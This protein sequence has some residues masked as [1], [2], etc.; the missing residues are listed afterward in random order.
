[1]NLPY[2]IAAARRLSVCRARW[3]PYR[4]TRWRWHV[5]FAAIDIAGWLTFGPAKLLR[6]VLRG[7]RA[8]APEMVQSILVVQLDHLGDAVMSLGLLRALRG[9]FAQARIHVLASSS[10]DELFAMSGLV[11][12][13][14]VMQQTRFSRRG[15]LAWIAEIIRWGR[16]LRRHRFDLAID[17]RGEL[18]HALLMWVSRARRRVGWA[19]GGGGFLL[20]E[21]A[22]YVPGR[23]EVMSR[24]ALADL[25]GIDSNHNPLPRIK[26][27]E[28]ALRR[29]DDQLRTAWSAVTQAGWPSSSHHQGACA[30][31]S[32]MVALHLGAGTAAKRW[33]AESWRILV[34][35]LTCTLDASVVLLGTR[36]DDE[37]GA[38]IARSIAA[39]AGARCLNLVGRLSLTSLAALLYRA[40]LMI[41]ADSG[42]AHIAAAVGTP[43]LALFSGTNDPEQWKPWGADVLVLRR[44][45]ACTP[46]HRETCAWADHPCMTGITVDMVMRAATEKLSGGAMTL[47]P[48]WGEGRGEGIAAHNTLPIWTDR[49]QPGCF[50]ADKLRTARAWLMS[51]WMAGVAATYLW[52]MLRDYMP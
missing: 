21:R 39:A 15:G 2:T 13:V 1:V 32:P 31:R 23:H 34:E 17:V 45:P 4:Y 25:L 12:H 18:P 46:C 3:S 37:A 49:Q 52:F 7:G 42:P 51:L 50:E 47:S 14:H 33:P 28:A 43:V 35:R 20:T 8:I 10:N 22:T 29:V 40:D 38:I 48:F 11:D 41:G 44:P 16:R 19:C 27:V 36:E 6:A 24:A 5:L 9:H 26:P 30:P